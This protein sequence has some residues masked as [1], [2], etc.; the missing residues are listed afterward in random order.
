MERA[1][2]WAHTS[3]SLLGVTDH[4]RLARRAARCMDAKE[5]FRRH[6]EHAERIGIPQVRLGGE[7]ELRQVGERFQVAGMAAQQIETHSIERRILVSM[8]E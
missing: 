7:R 1:T 3:I 4:C 8:V 2:Q 6:G 5:P